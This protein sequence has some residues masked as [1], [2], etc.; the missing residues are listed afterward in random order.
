MRRG[1]AGPGHGAPRAPRSGAHRLSPATRTPSAPAP[2]T[3][4]TVQYGGHKGKVIPPYVGGL[5]LALTGTRPAGRAGKRSSLAPRRRT[6]RGSKDY[7]SRRASRDPAGRGRRRHPPPR[8]RLGAVVPPVAVSPAGR[9][10]HPGQGTTPPPSSR[11]AP[12]DARP[13]VL[14][15]PQRPG[16]P[17]E[18]EARGAAFRRGEPG[19]G[20]GLMQGMAAASCSPRS[21]KHRG[22]GFKRHHRPAPLNKEL[23]GSRV[24][25][26]VGAGCGRHQAPAGKA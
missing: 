9:R 3:R 12:R 24:S 26:S 2:L 4:V 16:A 11:R 7:D 19:G 20:L 25:S 13:R 23:C 1:R 18:A 14:K 15:G 10:C 5:P 6:A 17:A 21:H 8:G 22:A